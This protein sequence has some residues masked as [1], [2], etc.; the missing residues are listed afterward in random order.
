MKFAELSDSAKQNA[1]EK[2]RVGHLDYEW[3]DSVFDCAERIGEIIGIDF[4]HKRSHTPAIYFSGFSSQGD[5]ACFEGSYHY[6]KGSAKAIAAYTSD[7]ELLR[8]ARELQ[9]VQSRNF[10]KL[11]AHCRH[12]GRYNHSYSM[13]VDVSHTDDAYRAIPDD[14]EEDIRQLMRDFADWIYRTLEKEY[15]YLMSDEAITESI[16]ANGYDFDDEGNMI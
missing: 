10:Y 11:E 1:I 14:A 16:E 13:S 4:D 3:W 5:G 12:T 6:R 2:F 15:D 7:A 8:I 9:A